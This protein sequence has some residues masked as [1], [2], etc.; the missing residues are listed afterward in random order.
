MLGSLVER[1][2]IKK[3]CAE[4]KSFRLDIVRQRPVERDV[5]ACSLFWHNCSEKN[6]GVLMVSTLRYWPLLAAIGS[7]AYRCGASSYPN[8]SR[9][10]PAC[11]TGE[12]NSARSFFFSLYN[13][14]E[15]GRD[16]AMKLEWD[17]EFARLFNRISKDNTSTVE[18]VSFFGQRF[19]NIQ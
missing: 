3:D 9:V 11:G 10:S 7:C 8:R 19:G 2:I 13:D 17:L 16:L 18:L 12:V 5:S 1:C 4:Y 6:S 15:V 14:L